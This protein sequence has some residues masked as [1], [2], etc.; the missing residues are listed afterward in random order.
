MITKPKTLSTKTEVKTFN[1][2]T[3][4]R[5]RYSSKKASLLSPKQNRK[6]KKKTIPHPFILSESTK[7]S[8]NNEKKDFV[9]LKSRI[10]NFFKEETYSARKSST[11]KKRFDS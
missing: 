6:L 2:M 4:K 11:K 8:T 3:D 7:H 10:N 5:N 1:L 9:S